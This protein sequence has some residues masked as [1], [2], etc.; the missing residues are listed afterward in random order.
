MY[1]DDGGENDGDAYI[2]DAQHATLHGH[3]I[4]TNH[5][6]WMARSRTQHRLDYLSHGA[7][8]SHADPASPPVASVAHTHQEEKHI[9]SRIPTTAVL[10]REIIDDHRIEYDPREILWHCTVRG[11]QNVSTRQT[12]HTV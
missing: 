6:P 2:A 11:P 3:N 10:P 5:Q 1:R 4:D 8:C 9:R 12:A 7:R